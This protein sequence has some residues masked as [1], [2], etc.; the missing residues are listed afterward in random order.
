[1]DRKT[2]SGVQEFIFSQSWFL[3]IYVYMSDPIIIQEL[4]TTNKFPRKIKFG[5]RPFFI[6]MLPGE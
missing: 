5:K 4:L 2:K 3:K 1:M 6:R